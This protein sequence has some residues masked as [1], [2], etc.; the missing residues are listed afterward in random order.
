MIRNKEFIKNNKQDLIFQICDWKSYDVYVHDEENE[1]EEND[2]NNENT[3]KKKVKR[4]VIQGYGITNNGNS[5]SIRVNHFQPHFYIK[6]P[7]TWDDRKLKSLKNE[8]MKEIPEYAQEGLGIFKV[9]EKKE[10]YG[11]TN[12]KLFKYGYFNFKNQSCYYSFLR[13]LKEKK[14]YIKRLQEEFDFSK[15]I[16]ETK[17]NPLLRFYHTQNIEPAGWCMISAKQYNFMNHEKETRCQIEIQC[18]YDKV[19]RS[20]IKDIAKYLIASFDIECTSSDGSFPKAT[21]KED[22]MIQI[23]TTVY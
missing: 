12:N 21:R 4:L 14:I 8:I 23:G 3:Y 5:I 7:E 6:I 15:K 17:V 10:F 20:D 22:E 13:V 1:D 9:V 16:Y 2:E 11:F 18:S 19:Q